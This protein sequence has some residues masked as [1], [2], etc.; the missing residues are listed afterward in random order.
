MASLIGII[1]TSP[2]LLLTS[3]TTATTTATAGAPHARYNLSVRVLMD[4]AGC[5]P[6]VHLRRERLA[7]G[8]LLLHRWTNV[9]LGSSTY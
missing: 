8:L 3:G 6:R 1:V 4:S 5:P 7:F 9:N 2:V